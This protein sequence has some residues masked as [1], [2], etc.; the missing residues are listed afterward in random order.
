MAEALHDSDDTCNANQYVLFADCATQEWDLTHADEVLSSLRAM[1]WTL[2]RD[3]AGT[4]PLPLAVPTEA[5]LPPS[6]PHRSLL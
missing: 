2:A 6:A 3:S 5:G 1:G 4:I